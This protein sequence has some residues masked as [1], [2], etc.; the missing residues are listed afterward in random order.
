MKMDFRELEEVDPRL[1]DHV[2]LL[3]SMVGEEDRH[4]AGTEGQ[5]GGFYK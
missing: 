2:R 5:D 4:R 3:H 1:L